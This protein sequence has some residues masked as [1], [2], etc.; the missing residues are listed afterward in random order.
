M[1]A[2]L[3]V[4]SAPQAG[5]PVVTN[6]A[7]TGTVDPGCSV[8]DG[9]QLKDA[10]E[11]GSCLLITLTQLS[12]DAYI[13]HDEILVSRT[14]TIVGDPTYLPLIKPKE[15]QRAFRVVAGGYLTLHFVTL[16]PGLGTTTTRR[17]E[18]GSMVAQ[19][20]V[21]RGGAVLFEAGA[22]G[23]VF[24]G[25]MFESMDLD[26]EAV[27]TAVQL[28]QGDVTTRVFGGFVFMAAGDVQFLG[29]I[30]NR[31]SIIAGKQ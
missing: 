9:A 8:A 21:V 18:D 12:D 24:M 2:I 11:K 29:C 14:V 15:A 3:Q 4:D 23:G 27:S 17:L 16:H 25:V 30:F 20:V 10:V 28:S 19:Q 6:K 13:L 31:L 5:G 22:V 1:G 7:T 26:E